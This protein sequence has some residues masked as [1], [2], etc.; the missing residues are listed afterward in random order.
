M[1]AKDPFSSASPQSAQVAADSSLSKLMGEL[2]HATTEALRRDLSLQKS[3]SEPAAFFAGLLRLLRA[4]VPGLRSQPGVGFELFY[5]LCLARAASERPALRYYTKELGWQHLSRR[6]L[7]M[8][9]AR[10]AARWQRAGATAGKKVALLTSMG[11]ELLIGLLAAY[12][13]GL[14]V[15]LISPTGVTFVQER[16]RQSGCAFIATLPWLHRSLSLQ[17]EL[18]RLL[19][20]P[21]AELGSGPELGSTHLYSD[22]EPASL[23]FS[24]SHDVQDAPVPLAAQ[25]AFLIALRDGLFLLRLREG[26]FLSCIGGALLQYQPALLTAALLAG[27]TYVH[28]SEEDL[29]RDLRLLTAQP[30][31]A[32]VLSAEGAT[33]LAR[34]P[35]GLLGS[36]HALFCDAAQGASA[37]SWHTVLAPLGE[38]PPLF[39]QLYD[40]AAGG[41]MFFSGLQ[42]NKG[43]LYLLPAPGVPF[44]LKPPFAGPAMSALTGVAAPATQPWG[45]ALFTERPAGY[46]YL[47]TLAP[48]RAGHVFPS[49]D[50]LKAIA[51]VP[52]VDASAVVDLLPLPGQL[53]SRFHL[54]IFAGAHQDLSELKARLLTRLA[55]RLP[56]THAPDEIVM[57]PLF[58]RRKEGKLDLPWVR[59]QYQQGRLARKAADPLFLR[60][61]KLRSLLQKH[62]AGHEPSPQ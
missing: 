3:Y 38:L 54:L 15:T 20:P 35:R 55:E 48:R 19:L 56:A 4:E 2:E 46:V 17:A 50:V 44:T 26:D 10:L 36:V 18:A 58:A 62:T 59:Q 5:D 33:L 37:D 9:A 41:A 60:L 49:A 43:L 6:E 24:L 45:T 7:A 22:E 27:A 12:K 29:S 42:P 53:D 61:C 34:G 51:D 47:G 21:I 39:A 16:L 28:I 31:R 8:G 11:P 14:I 32:L 52:G 30:L 57:L 40:S 23:A 25:K 13:I 1:R